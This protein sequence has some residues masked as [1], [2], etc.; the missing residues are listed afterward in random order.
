MR[1]RR[2]DDAG[3]RMDEREQRVERVVGP[4][5]SYM[6]SVGIRDQSSHHA[7]SV[8]HRTETAEEW[9][10]VEAAVLRSR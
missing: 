4:V 3:P 7:E 6:L 10:C 2:T 1:A 8:P 5:S 9:A